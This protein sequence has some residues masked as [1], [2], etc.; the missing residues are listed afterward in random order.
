VGPVRATFD[1]RFELHDVVPRESYTIRAN[2]KGGPAGFAK[3]EAH[4]RLSDDA[5]AT[6]LHYTINASVG[7]KLA[8]VGSRLIDG[9]ARK[10]AEDFFACFGREM[11]GEEVAS[12]EAA[13]AG[14]EAVEAGEESRSEDRSQSGDRSHGEDR[15]PAG[16]RQYEGGGRWMIWVVAFVVLLLAILFA[17]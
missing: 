13:G 17:L 4:V 8:Q 2:V 10:M 9:T 6:W 7:G 16:A 3:G 1:A 14:E 15:H 12:R 5:E 11:S